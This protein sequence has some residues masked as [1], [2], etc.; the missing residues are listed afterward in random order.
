MLSVQAGAW[1]AAVESELGIAADS[2]KISA[3]RLLSLSA[4]SPFR[5][6]H[7]PASAKASTFIALEAKAVSVCSVWCVS[8]CEGVCRTI[9]NTTV[10]A[11]C[12]L[13]HAFCCND[14]LEYVCE[15]KCAY[16][17]C[18]TCFLCSDEAPKSESVGSLGYSNVLLLRFDVRGPPP[19]YV[20][21]LKRVKAVSVFG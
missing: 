11:R 2:Q 5:L 15:C 13:R 16:C 18:L 10:I 21:V 14:R 3:P 1:S 12:G 6:R 8:R 19:S 17:S 7:E 4:R 9:P 20:L